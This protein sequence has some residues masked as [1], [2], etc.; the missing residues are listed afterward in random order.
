MA[1]GS[2]DRTSAPSSGISRRR[3]LTYAGVGLAA[4]ANGAVL[5]A[6]GSSSGPASTRPTSAAQPRRGGTL[7]AGLTGGSSSDTLDAIAPINNVD[8]ARVLQ[9]NEPLISFDA[10]CLPTYCLAEEMTPNSDATEWTIR[11]RPGVTFHNGKDLTAD[12]VIYTIRQILTPSAKADGITALA[13][14]DAA[15]LRKLD[16]L[17]VR[18]PCKTPFSTLYSTLPAWYF[19]VIPVG[20]DP[21]HPVGTGPFKFESFTPGVQSV[22]T[23]YDDYWQAG[24]PYV[25]AVVIS[26]YS[27]ETSQVNALLSGQEHV[28]DL[29]S[30]SSMAGV[31]SGGHSVLISHGGGWTPF[32]MRVDQAPFNDARVRQAFRLIVDRPQMLEL[33][34]GGHGTIGND[35]FSIWD[36]VYDHA[37]PQRVQDIPQAKY[38]LKKAG[39]E[40]LHVELVTGDLAQGVLSAA[41]VFAQQATAAGVTVSIRTVSVAEFYGPDYLT[42]TFGQDFWYYNPYFFQAATSTLSTANVN[43]C[44]FSDPQ[45]DRLYSQ[46]LATTTLPGQ[47]AIAHEMQKID[48]DEGGYIIPY[49][50]P[51][52]DGYSKKVGGVVPSKTGLSFNAFDFKSMWL[53]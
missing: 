29:L 51:V 39:Q 50:P 48:Y 15:G 25:D 44:H 9:L 27:D 36:P 30:A 10:G 38:L 47:R 21:N 35:V 18:V 20:Y 11:L 7:R 33:V 53:I 26:D 37:L 22:F 41:Q 8:F 24:K 32:T 14:I 4:V 49:F 12:D 28:I 31:I 2:D 23:R 43:E 52:I 1:P 3:L 16:K 34:F 45:Y 5:E 42:W 46:A 6:C 13:P 40:G 17:T 19:Q